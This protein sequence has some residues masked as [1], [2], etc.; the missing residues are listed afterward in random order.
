M[1]FLRGIFLPS[2]FK[3]IHLASSWN[4]LSKNLLPT[5]FPPDNYCCSWSFENL[6]N[7]SLSSPVKMS[8][9]ISVMLILLAPCF[10]PEV[11]YIALLEQMESEFH[12]A[13]EIGW[14][15]AKNSVL[16]AWR[17]SLRKAGLNLF[18]ALEERKQKCHISLCGIKLRLLRSF[19]CRCLPS[20]REVI[21][22][23][24]VKWRH[25]YSVLLKDRRQKPEQRIKKEIIWT[26]FN[27]PV[28]MPISA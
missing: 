15:P 17:L 27:L 21:E 26:P 14:L 6:C 1:P 16:V 4:I 3:T 18:S 11:E 8:L 2:F 24:G 9:Q 5:E 10:W 7:I 19:I 12:W 20:I 25:L 28:W 23:F 13:T 22:S